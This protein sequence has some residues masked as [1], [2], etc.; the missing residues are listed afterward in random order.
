ME[1][2]SS[3]LLYA[4]NQR[5]LDGSSRMTVGMRRHLVALGACSAFLIAGCFLGR[6]AIKDFNNWRAWRQLKTDGIKIQ[7]TVK[8]LSN[9][10]NPWSGGYYV[11][12]EFD[13]IAAARTTG[14]RAC[15]ELFETDS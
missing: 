11:D 2:K 12:Y 5:V 14:E 7:A 13:S 4:K 9:P 10:Q 8:E 3:Y 1:T 6:S 15:F